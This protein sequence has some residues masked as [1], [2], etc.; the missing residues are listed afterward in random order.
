MFRRFDAS[1][2]SGEHRFELRN[3]EIE[4]HLIEHRRTGLQGRFDEI[5][6]LC[7]RAE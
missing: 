3:A 1:R 6:V 7:E 5:S 2:P 4:L